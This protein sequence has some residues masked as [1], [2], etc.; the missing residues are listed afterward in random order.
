MMGINCNSTKL[1]NSKM[2]TLFYVFIFILISFNVVASLCKA[3][4]IEQLPKVKIQSSVEGAEL[5]SVKWPYKIK[6]IWKK[7]ADGGIE[8]FWAL[9]LKMPGKV[10]ITS[11]QAQKS[12]MGVKDE[13]APPSGGDQTLYVG[14]KSVSDQLLVTLKD[15]SH[16]EI[17]VQ[18]T[19]PNPI[20]VEQDCEELNLKLEPSIVAS[21]DTKKVLKK[22]VSDSQ[23]DIP[24]YLAY[25][26]E[27]I[28][29]GVRLAVTSP[30]EMAWASNS[31]FESKGKGKNWK[32]FDLG[33]QLNSF[34]KQEVG[35]IEFEWQNNHYP[36]SIIVE[37]T[38]II[39]PISAFVFSFGMINM[40]LKTNSA[41]KAIT[42]ASALVTFELRPFSPN[43]SF[44][45]QGMTSIPSV[46]PNSYFNHTETMGY[47]GYTFMEKKNWYLEPRAYA[48]VINGVVKV[49]NY[50]YISS[51][52]AVGGLLKYRLS[53]RNLFSLE[54]FFMNFNSQSIF[55]TRFTYSRKNRNQIG[56]WGV[57]F[58]YQNLGM[59]LQSKDKSQASQIYLGPYL[60]F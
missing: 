36:F 42:K 13:S 17:N 38:E 4:P 1:L 23:I 2:N 46:D 6:P 29:A 49:L 57:E 51:N 45:G 5:K 3:E 24:Y 43:Y 15:N 52:F 35:K 34:N 12:E 54:T 39:R 14:L 40:N 28:P 31:L 37:K 44:G 32:N 55:S 30:I 22:L 26:C 11:V 47:V 8:F 33:V 10:G 25:K 7:N 48:Y 19:F 58:V 50:F 21:T 56:G 16:V 18:L 60:E 27:V 20:I 53:H 9:Q 41:Q 59:N